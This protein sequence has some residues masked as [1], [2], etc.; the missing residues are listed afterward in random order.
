MSRPTTDL[1]HHHHVVVFPSTGD[2]EATSP[3][4]RAAKHVAKKKKEKTGSLGFE[5]KL[6]A[7]AD[8]LRS[9]MDPA[10]YKHVVLGLIFLK[11]ISDSFK[12]RQDQLRKAICEDKDS[13]YYVDDP[14]EREKELAA[15]LE[16]RDE[17]TAE[18]VFWV[19]IDARWAGI[20]NQ[21][22]KKQVKLPTDKTGNIG[23]LVDFAMEA[24][25]H[26]NPTLRGTL[27]ERRHVVPGLPVLNPSR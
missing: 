5:D 11:Y 6:W 23:Q 25:E 20:Q 10:E 3:S 12:A 21:A 4:T 7:S 19:P 1:I 27:P 13:D 9:N 22:K 24:I 15:V 16:D 8:L 26:E 18:N 2:V 14:K 17:Y